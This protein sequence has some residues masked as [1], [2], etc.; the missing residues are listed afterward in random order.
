MAVI[1]STKVVI[2][3]GGIVFGTSGARGFVVDFMPQV[4][5]AFTHAFV[6]IMRQEFD[7]IQ[8]ALA[9]N[10]RSSSYAMLCSCDDSGR[11]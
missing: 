9:I 1:L 3:E 5:A 4:C 8:M 2:S 10:N 7:D 11:C 6:A